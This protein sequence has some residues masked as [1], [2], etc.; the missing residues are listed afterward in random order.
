M[1]RQAT[2]ISACAMQVAAQQQ[3]KRALLLEQQQLEA[4]IRHDQAL[5]ERLHSQVAQTPAAGQVPGSGAASA[6]GGQEQASK[7]TGTA[8]PGLE[9]AD[10]M[11]GPQGGERDGGAVPGVDGSLLHTNQ[12]GQEMLVRIDVDPANLPCLTAGTPP[13]VVKKVQAAALAAHYWQQTRGASE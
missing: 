12:V 4:R 1:Q 2:H 3:K 13:S 7:T 10:L 8:G 11:A 6:A 9:G 5:L